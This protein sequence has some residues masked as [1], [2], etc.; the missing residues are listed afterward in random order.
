[1]VRKTKLRSSCLKVWLWLA[2]FFLW[3]VSEKEVLAFGVL[4]R[5]ILLFATCDG[6]KHS[7]RGKSR[8]LVQTSASSFPGA[9][10]VYGTGNLISASCNRLRKI[11]FSIVGSPTCQE[12]AVWTAK[13]LIS[14]ALAVV[15][16]LIVVGSL[17]EGV[18]GLRD[19]IKKEKEQEAKEPEEYLKI[20]KLNDRLESYLYSF[21]KVTQGKQLALFEHKTRNFSRA[22]RTTV[23]PVVAEE[24]ISAL[25]TADKKYEEEL[26][27][28]VSERAELE[29]QLRVV[30]AGA[31]FDGDT[32]GQVQTDD[33][34][35][36]QTFSEIQGMVDGSS[37]GG[38]NDNT[39]AQQIESRKGISRGGKS[40]R[41]EN[42]LASKIGEIATK[43]AKLEASYLHRVAEILSTNQR[44]RLLMPTIRT[45]SKKNKET[46][47]VVFRPLLDNYSKE[48][49]CSHKVFVLNFNGDQTPSQLSALRAEVTAVIRAS[50]PSAGDECVL[51]LNSPG[52]SVTGYGLAAAQLER[53]KTSGIR[54]TVCVEQTAASGGYL[55]ACVA[56]RIVAS[57]FAAL[58]SIGV[59]TEI[60]NVYE[61]LTREGLQFNT[62]TAGSY[63]RTLTPFKKTEQDDILKVTAELEEVLALFKQFASRHRPSLDVEA[64]ATGEVWFGPDALERG[65]CDEIKTADDVLL[66]FLE[67]NAEIFSITYRGKRG[68]L[69]KVLDEASDEAQAKHVP[70]S[71]FKRLMAV[72][73]KWLK[74]HF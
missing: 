8:A 67:N 3:Y 61:R 20:E 36:N 43:Q 6:Q 12:L 22:L 29:E 47:G 40:K 54:L 16:I 49:V 34:S 72:A 9:G 28:T 71:V 10:L 63:K 2:A 19:T 56:D 7:C 42:D 53:F 74:R 14:W 15:S 73:Q 27:T 31:D 18:K 39:A 55:M 68:L 51:V 59:V 57:P 26:K 62:I 65:L 23:S 5:S 45:L 37:P 64:V 50:N 69:K 11:I 35:N 48:E 60:P 30:A 46:L 21:A 52:G 41:K 33:N 13:L 32:D 17:S 25:L 70:V 44:N 4:P 66:D 1:M 58:G 24:Q 38:V